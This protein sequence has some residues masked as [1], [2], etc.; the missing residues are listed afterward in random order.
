MGSIPGAVIAAI[1]LGVAETLTVDY[2]SPRWGVGVFY[3]V[4]LVVLMVRPQGLMG[5]RLREDVAA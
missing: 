2:L 4:I 5:S 1:M 3:V